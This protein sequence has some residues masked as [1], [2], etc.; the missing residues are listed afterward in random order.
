[1]RVGANLSHGRAVYSKTC[2]ACH[3]LFGTGGDLGPDI[4]GSNRENLDYI[5][6]NIIDPNTEVAKEYMLT[7]IETRDGGQPPGRGV[8]SASP[9]R[10]F[11]GRPSRE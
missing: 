7:T 3:Q 4:T 9:S 6:E 1:M 5:L 11:R 10:L 2:M 8:S